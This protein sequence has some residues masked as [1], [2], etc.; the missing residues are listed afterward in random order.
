MGVRGDELSVG[1]APLRLRSFRT[2]SLQVLV[3]V[4]GFFSR[5]S[6]HLQLPTASLFPRSSSG[7]SPVVAGAPPYYR[8]PRTELLRPSVREADSPVSL[9]RPPAE[10]S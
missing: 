3:D 6:Y 4:A 8:P 5:L 10:V 2:E 1:K 7:V 9:P